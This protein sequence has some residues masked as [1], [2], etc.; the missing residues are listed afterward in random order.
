MTNKIKCR[1]Q[2]HIIVAHLWQQCTWLPTHKLQQTQTEFGY[3]K[4]SGEQRV[5]ELA[6][7]APDI[8]RVLRD[9]IEKKRGGEIGLDPRYEY[10]RFKSRITHEEVLRNNREALTYF[11]NYQLARAI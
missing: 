5:R 1:T 3:I 6:R 11:D 9:K 8:P 7:N 10:F 2:W 4:P